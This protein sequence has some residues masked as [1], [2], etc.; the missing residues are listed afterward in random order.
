MQ[1]G[2]LGGKGA[3]TKQTFLEGEQPR[4]GTGQ[5]ERR[6]KKGRGGLTQGMVPLPC[7]L[8]RNK[9]CHVQCDVLRERTTSMLDPVLDLVCFVAKVAGRGD[10]D[11]TECLA[12]VEC[13][14]RSCNIGNKDNE[15]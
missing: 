12:H 9:M 15:V 6:I 5:F 4:P 2:H 13:D 3:H 10:C 14:R 1:T 11:V 7:L 8:A